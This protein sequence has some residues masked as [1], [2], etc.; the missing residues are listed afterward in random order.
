MA[1]AVAAAG[2]TSIGR[3][4]LQAG[5]VSAPVTQCREDDLGPVTDAVLEVAMCQRVHTAADSRP[6][7]KDKTGRPDAAAHTGRVRCALDHRKH[8]ANCP[9]SPR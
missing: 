1:S 5:R 3:S 6:Y 4:S 9:L 8:C 7:N 2:H